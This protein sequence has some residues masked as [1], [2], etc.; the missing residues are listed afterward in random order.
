MEGLIVLR[1]C[2][3]RDRIEEQII[4]TQYKRN[5]YSINTINVV[6]ALGTKYHI[7]IKKGSTNSVWNRKV[8]EVVAEIERYLNWALKG[9]E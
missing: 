1:K 2:L 5:K 4:T 7:N 9:V 6:T 8:S 3:G